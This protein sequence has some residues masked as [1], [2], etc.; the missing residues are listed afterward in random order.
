MDFDA[1]EKIKWDAV[2]EVAK[3]PM[4]S[5]N[6]NSL[7]KILSRVVP[8]DGNWEILI[9][10]RKWWRLWDKKFRVDIYY[11]KPSE[12]AVISVNFTIQ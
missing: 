3:Y 2:R 5:L 11:T 6:E 4:R 8:M 1:I 12:P 9:T 7:G 10:K